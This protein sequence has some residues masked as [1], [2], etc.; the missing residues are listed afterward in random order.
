MNKKPFITNPAR[1]CR[2]GRAGASD[3]TFEAKK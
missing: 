2:N 3:I 1:P